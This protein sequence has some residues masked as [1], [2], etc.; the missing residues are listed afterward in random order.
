MT[1][2]RFLSTPVDYS[3]H[4]G[5]FR[6][7]V[8]CHIDSRPLDCSYRFCAAHIDYSTRVPSPPFL[9]TNL[10]ASLPVDQSSRL[11]SLHC[12]QSHQSHSS[13][14]VT[15]ILVISTSRISPARCDASDPFSPD[16]SL[17]PNPPRVDHPAHF[18]SSLPL[19]MSEPLASHRRTR[20]PHA[21][22]TTHPHPGLV[23]IDESH[24]VT[25]DHSS[26][27]TSI[28]L[29][30]SLLFSSTGQTTSALSTPRDLES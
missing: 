7:D 18:N 6:T 17:H 23:P 25:P 3:F 29:V 10:F 27:V 9:S 4:P 28:R 5:S 20:S 24:P 16:T 13:R 19:D 11:I 8:S 12:D 14:R 1:T 21:Q 22:S 15:S 26:R 2:N 30:L